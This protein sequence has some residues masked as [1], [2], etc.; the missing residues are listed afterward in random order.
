MKNIFLISVKIEEKCWSYE[1]DQIIIVPVQASTKWHALTK[2]ESR[3][4]GS[5]VPNFSIVKIEKCDMDGSFCPIIDKE[6]KSR[7]RR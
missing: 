5:E 4:E 3:W 7:N 6:Q 1:K 2:A